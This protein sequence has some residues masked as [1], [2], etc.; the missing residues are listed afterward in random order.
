MAVVA[1]ED[2]ADSLSALLTQAGE[3]VFRIGR[4]VKARNGRPRVNLSGT[5][6]WRTHGAKS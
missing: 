2:R 6:A 3:Q 4:I 5:Q 1:A